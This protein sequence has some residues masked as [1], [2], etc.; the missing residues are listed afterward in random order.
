MGSRNWKYVELKHARMFGTER[1]GPT[2]MDMPDWVTP[3]FAGE[4]KSSKRIPGWLYEML[5]QSTDNEL[6]YRLKNDIPK[7]IPIVVLHQDG[8]DYGR[9]VVIMELES[10]VKE[11]LPLIRGHNVSNNT[12]VGSSIPSNQED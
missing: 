3:V 9:D 10:F 4:T 12:S 1:I 6:R 8:D 11:L 2:G 7:L 5:D